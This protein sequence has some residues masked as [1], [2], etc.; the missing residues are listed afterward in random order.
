MNNFL[1][2]S[3]DSTSGNYSATSDQRLKINI[4]V[5]PSV[6]EKLIQLETNNYNY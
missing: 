3:F 5:I 6:Y 1:K 4:T 2:R